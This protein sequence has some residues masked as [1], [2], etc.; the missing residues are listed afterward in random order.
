M[1][2]KE[3]SVMAEKLQFAARRLTGELKAELCATN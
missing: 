1:P 2:W 3:C